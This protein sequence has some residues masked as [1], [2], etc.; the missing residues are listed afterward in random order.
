[1]VWRFRFPKVRMRLRG[2]E[3][4]RQASAPILDEVRRRTQQQFHAWAAMVRASMEEIQALAEEIRD[5]DRAL[6]DLLRSP[7]PDPAAIGTLILEMQ[8][9]R[10]EIER[11]L[12]ALPA[13]DALGEGG[14]AGRPGDPLPRSKP[15]A[16]PSRP[17]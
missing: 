15:S 9:R 8:A 14:E 5:R 6:E 12:D 7:K 13:L 16:L 4:D 17:L 2:K 1:M 10:I 3:H 11:I